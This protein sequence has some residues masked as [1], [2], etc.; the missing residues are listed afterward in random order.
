MQEHIGIAVA[1]SALM[2]GDLNAPDPEIP[3]LRK[4]M[5]IYS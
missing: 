5:K 4:A 3:A 2:V 1:F